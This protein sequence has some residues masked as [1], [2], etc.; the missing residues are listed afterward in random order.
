MRNIGKLISELRKEQNITQDELANRLQITK[1]TVSNYERGKRLPSY[2]ALEAIADELNVPMTFFLTKNEQ[3]EELA[4]IYSG[5]ACAQQTGALSPAA[6]RVAR[7]YENL[8]ASGKRALDAFC[9][10][11]EGMG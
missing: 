7:V 1:Q 3:A 5:Y 2:E 9:D 4:K 11:I 8:S 6:L 10:F